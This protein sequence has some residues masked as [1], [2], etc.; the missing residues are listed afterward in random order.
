MPDSTTSLALTYTLFFHSF[1]T[2]FQW[3]KTGKHG[4]F[5]YNFIPTRFE[6]RPSI[7][8]RYSGSHVTSELGNAQTT[9]TNASASTKTEQDIN[10]SYSPPPKKTS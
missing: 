10:S 8:Q 3:T 4:L 9:D 5:C 2:S 7:R 1:I 6:H